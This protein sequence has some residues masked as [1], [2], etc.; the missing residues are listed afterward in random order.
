LEIYTNTSS[1]DATGKILYQF[2]EPD[3]AYVGCVSHGGNPMPQVKI[4]IGKVSNIPQHQNQFYHLLLQ[5]DITDEF[6][7]DIKEFASGPE[8][9]Q[10]VMYEITVFHTRFHASGEDSGRNLKCVSRIHG[11]ADLKKSVSGTIDVLCEHSIL[12]YS[13]LFYSILF[14]SILFYITVRWPNISTVLNALS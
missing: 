1:T 3:S 14:Y 11:E 2:R 6:T 10:E 13:I 8:G 12:F 5:T 9:L 4:S 7:T